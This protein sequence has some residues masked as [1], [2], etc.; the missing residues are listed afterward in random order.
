MLPI[1]TIET[2]ISFVELFKTDLEHGQLNHHVST[3]MNF[4]CVVT[5]KTTCAPMANFNSLKRKITIKS[6]NI[7]LIMLDRVC[8]YWTISRVFKK[9]THAILFFQINLYILRCYMYKQLNYPIIF[10]FQILI[11][12][13]IIISDCTSY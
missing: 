1:C 6:T 11:K 7:H 5:L 13:F 2:Q 4:F 12:N 9:H 10:F 8:N 3:S